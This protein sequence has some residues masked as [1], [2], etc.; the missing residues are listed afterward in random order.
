VR[1]F[2]LLRNVNIVGSYYLLFTKLLHVSVVQPSSSRNIFAR[3]YS[4]DNG[5]V[6]FRILVNI[7]AN[8]S[9]QFDW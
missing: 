6:A 2:L 8:Y 1:E 3:N 5:Y 4:T 9:D 7:M